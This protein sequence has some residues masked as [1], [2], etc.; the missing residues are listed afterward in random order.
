M[1]VLKGNQKEN[2][3]CWGDPRKEDT[4][5][6]AVISVDMGNLLRVAKIGLEKSGLAAYRK[7]KLPKKLKVQ[8][9]RIK[10]LPPGFCG[11]L[12]PA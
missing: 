9:L 3:H 8:K 5:S 4:H 12:W 10:V 1:V 2:N 11:I 6:H 7:D